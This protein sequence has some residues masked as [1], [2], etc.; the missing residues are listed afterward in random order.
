MPLQTDGADVFGQVE[1]RPPSRSGGQRPRAV[2]SQNA[3]RS[4][5]GFL[6]AM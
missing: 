2:V 1:Q 3:S 4:V 5:P 6:L